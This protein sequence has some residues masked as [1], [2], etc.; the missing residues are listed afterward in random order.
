[1]RARNPSCSRGRRRG[2]TQ[3]Q[4]EE[5]EEL[6]GELAETT[7]GGVPWENTTSA[8]LPQLP[9]GPTPASSA[10]ALTSPGSVAAALARIEQRQV[11]SE[12]H[13]LSLRSEVRVVHQK[14]DKLHEQ[15]TVLSSSE[16][17]L[18]KMNHG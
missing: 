7:V 15:I 14:L 10:D 4:E 12:R 1:M 13:N 9:T 5:L 8:T 3:L 6:E 11:L 16:R 2:E 18:H 17:R